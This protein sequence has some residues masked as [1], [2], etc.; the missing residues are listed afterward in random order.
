MFLKISWSSYNLNDKFAL[1][2]LHP[3][4]YIDSSRITKLWASGEGKMEPI[5]S[6]ISFTAA[7]YRN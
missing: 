5:F 1:E 7:G 3:D 4:R 6:L 2:K